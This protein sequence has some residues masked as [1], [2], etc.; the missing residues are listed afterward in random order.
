[1]LSLEDILAIWLSNIS[2]MSVSDEGYSRNEWCALNMKCTIL[3]YCYFFVLF[4]E[5]ILHSS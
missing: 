3:F 1:M 5:E 4:L 2:I